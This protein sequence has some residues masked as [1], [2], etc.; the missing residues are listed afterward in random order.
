MRYFTFLPLAIILLVSG[1][2][3]GERKDLREEVSYSVDRTDKDLG[4]LVNRDKLNEQQR[5]KF[6]SAIKDLR[7]LSEAV[8]GERWKNERGRLERAV[9]N[10]D[11]VVKN[12]TLKDGDR[13]MLGIDVHT[14]RGVLESWKKFEESTSTVK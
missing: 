7:A 1:G 3:A 13:Q 2:Y 5:D 9:D 4:D 12:A 14:L 6:D 8:A 11:F 10:I